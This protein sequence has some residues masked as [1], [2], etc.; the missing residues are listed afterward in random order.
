MLLLLRMTLVQIVHKVIKVFIG[1]FLL[2]WNVN[3]YI[4]TLTWFTWLAKSAEHPVFLL[5]ILRLTTFFF[6]T[7]QLGFGLL[8]GLWFG[9]HETCSNIFACCSLCALATAK[10]PL[11]NLLILSH[12][13][14][15]LLLLLYELHHPWHQILMRHQE[16][17]LRHDRLVRVVLGLCVLDVVAILVLWEGEGTGAAL[18]WELE[19]GLRLFYLGRHVAYFRG[20]LRGEVRRRWD[21]ALLY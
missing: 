16:V 15:L 19:L 1:F 11:I 9:L 10:Q 21:V 8:H 2:L 18:E 3:W 5:L 14:L 7:L 12:H 13:D 4:L 6:L 20:H 17:V